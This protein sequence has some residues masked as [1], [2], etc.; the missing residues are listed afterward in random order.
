MIL[1]NAPHCRRS[2]RLVDHSSSRKE[3]DE[4]RRNALAQ[5]S[6]VEFLANG[7][8]RE[9]EKERG[10]EGETEGEIRRRVRNIRGRRERKRKRG[11]NIRDSFLHISFS[12]RQRSHRAIGRRRR[13]KETPPSHLAAAICLYFGLGHGQF[14]S[15]SS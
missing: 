10:R 4:E 14:V 8:E 13:P 12:S 7:R 1:E 15:D 11:R 6:D 2:G 5:D 3:D 9:R